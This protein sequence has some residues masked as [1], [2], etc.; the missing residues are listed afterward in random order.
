[1]NLFAVGSPYYKRA[2]A[3]HD[4]RFK[5]KNIE[6][7]TYTIHF[8]IPRVGQLTRTLELTHSFADAKGRIERKFEYTPD[9]LSLLLRPEERA[10]VSVRELGISPRSRREFEKA[11]IRLRADDADSAL[12]HLQK[13]IDQSPE[14]LEAINSTGIIYFQRKNYAEAEKFFR[15]AL[16]LDADAFEPQLNLGGVLLMQGKGAEA[17]EVNEQAYNVFPQEALAAAQL[18]LSY[19]LLGDYGQAIRYLD[20]AKELDAAH[21]TFPQITLAQIFLRLNQPED[22][23]KEVEEFLRLHPDSAEVPKAR[24]LQQIGEAMLKQ[25]ALT[26]SETSETR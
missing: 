20:Q 4:G 23:M 12:F 13:A 7:G 26:D 8:A 19:F 21:F 25:Q 9:D 1:V 3:Q 5:F 17:R 6:P 11:Q 24:E 16:E 22:A 14:F 15:M 10:T 18:G 2:V